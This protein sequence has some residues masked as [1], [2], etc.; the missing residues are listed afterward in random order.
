MGRFYSTNVPRN[1]DYTYKPPFELMQKAIAVSDAQNDAIWNQTDLLENE[2][3]KI[4]SMDQDLA[5]T[6]AK[7]DY[8][9]NRIKELTDE[10]KDPL[11]WRKIMPKLR[12]AGRELKT[13]LTTGALSKYQENR[14]AFDEFEAASKLQLMNNTISQRDYDIAK[15][16]MLD[17]FK[18]TNYDAN[19]GVYNKF[20]PETLVNTPEYAKIAKE[21]S[22][23]VMASVTDRRWDALKG[24]YIRTHRESGTEVTEQ[25]LAELIDEAMRGDSRISNA[26]KQ[27]VRLG[28]MDKG[29]VDEV[30]NVRSSY[31]TNPDGSLSY[32]PMSPYAGIVKSRAMS[33]AYRN[34]LTEDSMQADQFALA[35]VNY[36]RQLA[37]ARMRN[38]DTNKTPGGGYNAFAN[39]RSVVDSFKG[40]EG[41]PLLSNISGFS[42]K[43]E[44]AEAIKKYGTPLSTISNP[45]IKEGIYGPLGIA[46]VHKTVDGVDSKGNP[47]K[48][49]IVQYP[50]LYA[51]P[52]YPNTPINLPTKEVT[53]GERKLKVTDFGAMHE[54][55]YYTYGDKTF[56]YNGGE[57]F[58]F[59][60]PVYQLRDKNGKRLGTIDEEG[61][62]LNVNDVIKKSTP[63]M[64]YNAPYQPY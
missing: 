36:Q 30:G 6:Q 53:E 41:T 7:R 32:N 48:T 9:Q 17:G 54:G 34:E 22:D 10:A 64:T 60:Q 25:R 24:R 59:V 14:K 33:Q 62:N 56:K 57:S 52:M 23:K 20:A 38:D 42:G 61:L 15:K 19:T 21:A 49:A 39:F 50:E 35:D 8:Y 47:V 44:N 63:Q 45:I 58:E 12:N 43:D 4:K 55:Q 18:G 29:L 31:I 46:G 51:S 1:I 40:G 11:A 5:A 3:L 26:V 27:G 37:L 2:V 13:D 28:F 16:T